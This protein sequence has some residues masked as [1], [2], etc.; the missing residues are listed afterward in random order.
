[1]VERSDSFGPIF[2]GSP[3]GCWRSSMF[4]PANF[5]RGPGGADCRDRRSAGTQRSKPI[6]AFQC[7]FFFSVVFAPVIVWTVDVVSVGVATDTV[8]V[9]GATIVDVVSV[10]APCTSSVALTAIALVPVVGAVPSCVADAA[11]SVATLRGSPVAVV[12][13]TGERS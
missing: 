10:F 7:F 3:A 4:A 13:V 5:V 12:P 11:D 2:P 6:A 9:V 8:V 1:M